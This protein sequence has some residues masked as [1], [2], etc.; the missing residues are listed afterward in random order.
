[1]QQTCPALPF[2]PVLSHTA[3]KPADPGGPEGANA[4]VFSACPSLRFAA[5]RDARLDADASS[6]GGLNPSR[7][8]KGAGASTGKGQGETVKQDLYSRESAG[9][10]LR[11]GQ[12]APAPE[13]MG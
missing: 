8:R 13:F 5:Q 12:E 6:R 4:E 10:L 1:M 3:P 2:F 7:K 9:A 11:E